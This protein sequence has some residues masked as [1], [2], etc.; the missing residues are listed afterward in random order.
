MDDAQSCHDVAKQCYDFGFKL[1]GNIERDFLPE[2][3][4]GYWIEQSGLQH[5]KVD[6]ESWDTNL[7]FE[8][9]YHQLYFHNGGLY[10]SD[11][12]VTPVIQIDIIDYREIV[13]RYWGY[14]KHLYRV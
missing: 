5:F 12:G 11:R 1:P 4:I 8:G 9:Y 6:D 7:E 2:F 10:D 3:L 13:M 14:T